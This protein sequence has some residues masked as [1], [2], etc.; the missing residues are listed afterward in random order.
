MSNLAGVC[1]LTGRAKE[2]LRI[3]AKVKEFREKNPY[4]HYNLGT[5]AFEEGRYQEA[6]A[7]YRR[8]LKLKATEHNFYFALARAYDM[9]GQKAEAISNL[10]L[11]EKYASDAANKQRYAEK[12]ELLKGIRT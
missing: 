2:V 7:H 11:A 9:L 6:I 8:A 12:L 3:Q 4:H 10:Q 1:E 5:Q